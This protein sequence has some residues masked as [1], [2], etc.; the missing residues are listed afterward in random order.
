MIKFWFYSI[1]NVQRTF[2]CSADLHMVSI[3]G[4]SNSKKLDVTKKSCSYQN[5][6]MS[7]EQLF[8]EI[9]TPDGR[10]I[11]SE[12]KDRVIGRPFIHNNI[13]TWEF[14]R[15]IADVL[16]LPVIPSC[17]SDSTDITVGVQKQGAISFRDILSKRTIE[18]LGIMR[19]TEGIKSDYICCEVE[20]YDY[21]GLGARVSLNNIEWIVARTQSISK[22]GFITHRYLLMQ[23]GGIE[24]FY[25]CDRRN[26][27]YS[28]TGKVLQVQGNT[29]KVHLDIDG[30]Q[31][32]DTAYPYEY[33]PA[34]GNV[35]YSMPEIGTQV[36]LAV[37]EHFS[38]KGIVTECMPYKINGRFYKQKKFDTAEEK[39]ILLGETSILLGSDSNGQRQYVSLADRKGISIAS[40]SSA[41]LRAGEKIKL[42]AEGGISINTAAWM[43]IKQ[44]NTVN[45]ITFSGNEIIHTAT[46]H[47]YSS[48]TQ[49]PKKTEQKADTPVFQSMELANTLFGMF[50]QDPMDA[51]EKA[52]MGA[53]PI[54]GSPNTKKWKS[55]GS[56]FGSR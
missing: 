7:F 14:I 41:K 36:V 23:E 2:D 17:S 50:A 39:Q 5:S 46:Q 16:Y 20:T 56:G 10:I 55:G 44:S 40:R 47:S 51:A 3:T 21:F 28:L 24:Y 38:G 43:S 34:S 48:G 35:M 37:T 9:I 54:A 8:K 30:E 12:H 13:T 26:I 18:N 42:H 49:S 4:I 29:V 32:E 25:K 15:E 27:N 11:L 31:K 52:L 33:Y 1:F 19:R 45:E 53:Q 6:S 22:Q